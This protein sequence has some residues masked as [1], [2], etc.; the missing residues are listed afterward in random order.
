[1]KVATAEHPS[2]SNG[3]R[4]DAILTRDLGATLMARTSATNRG[5]GT[6]VLHY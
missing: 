1:M 3:W 2:D 5:M 4:N 6:L